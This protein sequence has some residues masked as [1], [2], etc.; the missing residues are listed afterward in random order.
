MDEK[1]QTILMSMNDSLNQIAENIALLSRGAL[2]GA[3]PQP[4]A[5]VVAAQEVLDTANEALEQAVKKSDE[6]QTSEEPASEED[7]EVGSRVKYVGKRE[8]LA[9]KIGAVVEVKERGWLAIA[10][11]GGE[12][13]S[14]RNNE[15]EAFGEQP[16]SDEEVDAEMFGTPIENQQISVEAHL[17]DSEE[18]KPIILDEEAAAYKIPTG[19]YA[20]FASIHHIYKAGEKERGWLRFRAGKELN[21]SNTQE[22]CKRYLAS[23]QDAEYLNTLKEV[24]A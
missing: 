17:E 3:V 15:V 4:P 13:S 18:P 22:M 20:K 24:S 11:Q 10:W 8:S 5:F 19:L 7:F 9:G 21:D 23:V 6:N 12:T 14:A 16:P 2:G 1:L